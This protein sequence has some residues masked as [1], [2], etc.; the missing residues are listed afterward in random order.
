MEYVSN[1][2]SFLY[3]SSLEYTLRDSVDPFRRINSEYILTILDVTVISMYFLV[4]GKDRPKSP[5]SRKTLMVILKQG[6]EAEAISDSANSLFNIALNAVVIFI[7]RVCCGSKNN[8]RKY[9]IL[10]KVYI[11]SYRGLW[12][13]EARFVSAWGVFRSTVMDVT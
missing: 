9:L 12:C 5:K 2:Q 1:H 7:P 3:K 8:R 11:A 10:L 6:L 4:W 13:S